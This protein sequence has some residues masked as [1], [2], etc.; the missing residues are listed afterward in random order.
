MNRLSIT[1]IALAASIVAH[2]DVQTAKAKEDCKMQY[3]TLGNGMNLP[4]LGFGTWTLTGEVAKASV[5]CAVET[6]Y[7]LIDSAQGYGNEADVWAGVVASGIDRKEVFITTKISPDVMREGTVRASIDR[8]VAA[9]GD[10]YIDLLLIHWPVKGKLVE[11]W[12][13]MEEFVRAGKVRM[14]GLSNCN[15]HHIDEVLAAATIKP[16]VNQI[17]IH[18]YMTQQEVS[19]ATFAKGLQVES[20]GPLGQG[21]N[22]VLQD[23]E[24]AKIAAA[25]GKSVAQTIIRWHL[26]RGLMVIPRSDKPAEIAEDIAVFDFELTPREMQ[27]ISGLNRNERTF[28]KN[29]PETFPW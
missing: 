21:R 1:G 13:T 27:I 4:Q 12:R 11:T 29:D 23:A 22:G 10:T 16:V 6:G 26:Q 28:E 19:G 25:H 9:F 15:P 8:S 17:E 14:I 24:I 7:R 5:K 20:W 3:V 2:A 18:P